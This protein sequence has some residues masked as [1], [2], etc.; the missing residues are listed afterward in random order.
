MHHSATPYWIFVAIPLAMWGV[1]LLVAYSRRGSVRTA[2]LGSRRLEL[3]TPADPATAFS[4]IQTIGGRF[5]VDDADPNAKILVLSTNPSFA[6]WGFLYPVFIHAEPGGGSR[7][8]IGIHSRFIQIGPL[9]TRAHSQCQEQI[10]QLLS[11]PV[12]RTA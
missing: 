7:I 12:A 9:V 6:T 10:A 11:P 2:S 8:E 3:G 1:G 5:K 4:R